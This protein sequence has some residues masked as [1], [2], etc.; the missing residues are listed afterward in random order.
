MERFTEKDL[1]EGGLELSAEQ[2]EICR[3]L[4][5]SAS[6]IVWPWQEAP[7]FLRK[8]CNKNGGDE[9][10]MVLCK[11]EPHFLP[12]WIERIDSCCEPDIYEVSDF[13]VYIGSH[14]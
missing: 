1:K 11:R 9:D 14:A 2:K 4:V 10:W 13:I 8:Y 7:E 5:K 6:Y 3:A 12:I